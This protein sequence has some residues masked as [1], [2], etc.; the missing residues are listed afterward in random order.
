MK[1]RFGRRKQ[2]TNRKKNE[3]NIKIYNK[4][5]TSHY[6]QFKIRQDIVEAYLAKIRVIKTHQHSCLLIKK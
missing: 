3:Q 6:F 5:Y 1:S 2:S 4:K